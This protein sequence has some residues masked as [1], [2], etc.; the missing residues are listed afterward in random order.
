MAAFGEPL[1]MFS[2]DLPGR[3]GSSPLPRLARI[4]PLVRGIGVGA[5]VVGFFAMLLGSADPIFAQILSDTFD[6][7]LSYDRIIR[8]GIVSAVVGW[9]TAGL[10]RRAAGI[11]EADTMFRPRGRAL[12]EARTVTLG[13][14]ALFAVFV[15]VQID[16]LFAGEVGR[17]ELGYAEYARRG[18][19]ELV[20]V[21]ACV[22]GL[23]LAVGWVVDRRDR[24][25]DTMHALLVVQTFVVMDSALL[26]M[27]AYVDAYGL[28]ELRFY[29]T[30][31]MSW[32]AV[33]LTALVATVL[34]SRRNRFALVGVASGL[35]VVLALVVAKPDARI[36]AVNI[37]RTTA[38]IEL[39]A[40]YLAGLSNDA[41]PL[42]LDRLSSGSQPSFEEALDVVAPAW[43]GRL[44]A[45]LADGWRSWS[46]AD[47]RAYGAIE[48]MN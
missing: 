13:L 48:A 40:E 47:S 16:H 34:R 42:V 5:I 31:F 35:I 41:V 7:D 20:A 22:A 2:E 14:N 4:F 21:D 6:L 44:E 17:I 10:A 36:A 23:I 1:F 28:S 27:R 45:N 29:T 15:A 37:D 8:F 33:V 39:D 9:W 18:F 3:I 30:V 46:L 25:L 43:T 26:R 24:F 12:T 11:G 38:E 19:F 32:T